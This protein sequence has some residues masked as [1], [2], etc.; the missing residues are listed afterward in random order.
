MARDEGRE[1]EEEEA[2]VD[3]SRTV[4]DPHSPSSNSEMYGMDAS[5]LKGEKGPT[6]C[7]FSVRGVFVPFPEVGRKPRGRGRREGAEEGEGWR[8]EAKRGS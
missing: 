5:T 8:G 7:A 4:G 6:S 1:R 2:E 3:F